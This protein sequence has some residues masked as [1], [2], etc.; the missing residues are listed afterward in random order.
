M[1]CL[2]FPM[3]LAID[4]CSAARL[5]DGQLV[6]VSVVIAV[7]LQHFC[8]THRPQLLLLSCFNHPAWHGWTCLSFCWLVICSPLHVFESFVAPAAKLI[9]VQSMS[10]SCTRAP[11][12]LSRLV[13][14]VE[15]FC[16][17]I[18]QITAPLYL[19]DLTGQSH[20][21]GCMMPHEHRTIL[22]AKWEQQDCGCR[23]R[24]QQGDSRARPCV[25]L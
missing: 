11:S 22:D 23:R 16:D 18:Y 19:P 3:T 9:A 21:C 2:L 20:H 15:S 4:A 17:C 1:C 5:A 24:A 8:L 14:G 25:H 7:L 13:A 10:V 12:S 6:S